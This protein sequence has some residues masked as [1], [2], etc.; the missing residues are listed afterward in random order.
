MTMRTPDALIADKTLE[1]LWE[2]IRQRGDLPGFTKAIS[3]VLDAMHGEEEREFNMTQTVMSDPG[4]TQKVLRLANSAMYSAFGQSIGTVSRA[5]M[6]LG[7]QAIGHLALGSR[8]IDELSASAPDTLSARLEMEKALLAGHVARQVAS[9]AN[10]RHAEEAVVCSMLHT[11]GR[12]MVAFYLPERWSQAQQDSEKT[13]Q[14]QDLVLQDMLGLSLEQIGRTIAQRWGLPSSLID[15]MRM[16]EPSASA[17]ASSEKVPHAEWLAAISSMTS[18]CATALC[19][20]DASGDTE[21]LRIA[22][23]YAGMLGV[24][25]AAVLQAAEN[26]KKTAESDLGAVHSTKRSNTE[27]RAR[28]QAALSQPAAPGIL[29]QGVLDMR[30]IS[31]SATPSQMMTMGLETLYQG[32]GFRRAIAFL[33]NVKEAKYSARMGFGAG[34]S[35]LIP[36]LVFND[37]YQPDVFHAALASDRIIFA[38]N[39]QD[40]KFAAKLPR[41]WQDSL[42]G[43]TGFIIVPLTVKRQPVG[44]IYGDWGDTAPNVKPSPAEFVILNDLRALVTQTAE[45]R[46]APASSGAH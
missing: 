46:H 27:K 26:A 34:V 7:T 43:A 28:A 16:V 29:Q 44:F 6:V 37:A 11:L 17:L 40:P 41:W 8:L 9:S 12:M 4:L 14:H 10:C 2:R 18:Q 19:Q 32:L 21:I 30:G 31:S 39:A 24:D 42:S 45:R 13:Q 38:E 23:A 15:S 35:A 36:Q 25:A 20:D 5:V 3:A 22:G 1:L 33:R